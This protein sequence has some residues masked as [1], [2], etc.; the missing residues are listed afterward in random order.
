MKRYKARL[1]AKG[2]TQ[3]YGIN[4]NETFSP[5]VRYESIRMIL[6]LATARNLRLKQFDV[7]T[8]FLNGNLKE[9]IYMVQP[10]GY[11]GSTNRVCKLNRSLYGLKQASRCWNQRLTDFLAKHGLRQT[12]SDPCTFIREGDASIILAIY[13]D[14]GLIATKEDESADCLLRELGNEFKIT[15]R[16]LKLFLGFQI[17]VQSDGSI[18]VNQANYI[19]KLLEKFRM[20]DA[21]PVAIPAEKGS[22]TRTDSHPKNIFLTLNTLSRSCR[23]PDVSCDRNTT[24]YCIC[25]RN[26]KSASQKP[27]KI[28]LE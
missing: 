14:D 21:N 24:G 9:E 18:F 20:E 23:K 10:E 16:E 4:Y 6:A 12:Q 27:Y 22:D 28:T 7:R 19:K 13:V 15:I 11:E 8:A 2:Y 17:S 5:V 26:R 25:G 3:K 1:V